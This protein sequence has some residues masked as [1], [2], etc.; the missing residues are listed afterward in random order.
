MAYL[1]RIIILDEPEL[2]LHPAALGLLAG[3]LKQASEHCQI[4]AAT[5]STPLLNHFDFQDVIVADSRDG[6]STFNRL[7]EA[8]YAAWLEDYSIGDLWER[9]VI[10]GGPN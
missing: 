7:I 1:S 8:D 9:N 6:S 3:M 4:L 10:G 5:Q 2:G